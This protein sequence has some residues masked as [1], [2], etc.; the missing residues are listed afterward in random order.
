MP[1]LGIKKWERVAFP[2]IMDPRG[3]LSVIQGGIDIDF[4]IA[5]VYF[6][7]DLPEGGERGGHAHR[8]LHQIY[9]AMN[10]S[11]D[12]HLTDGHNSETV[13]LDQ[14]NHGLHIRPGVWR[15]IGNFAQDSVCFV[16]A[17]EIYSEDDYIR[18]H[19]KFMDYVSQQQGIA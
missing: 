13:R 3:C 7:Y 10:G 8:N 17:S 9:L 16:L 2:R 15:T 19:S 1:I 4:D 12:V 18:D 11:F 14:P 5:R 6:L